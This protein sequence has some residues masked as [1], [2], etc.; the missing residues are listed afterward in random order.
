M[1]SGRFLILILTSVSFGFV[2]SFNSSKVQCIV[3]HLSDKNVSIPAAILQTSRDE[4]C[5]EIVK[6]LSESFRLD[7]ESQLHADDKKT[8]IVNLLLEHRISDIFLKG[9]VYFTMNLTQVINF[10][11]E[12]S[13]TTTDVLHA[14]RVI[15]SAHERYG[16]MFDE[17]LASHRDRDNVQQIVDDSSQ[18]CIKKY[19]FDRNIINPAEFDVDVT[20]I[21]ATECE[22][23]V[24]ALD[25]SSSNGLDVAEG[26]LFYGLP[27]VDVQK[28]T[29]QKFIADRV[30]LKLTSFEV[31]MSF[32]LSEHQQTK[33]RSDYV[34]WMT[35]N[36]RFLLGCLKELL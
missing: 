22:E 2:E 36:V 29:N 26:S 8:C 21:N 18:L 16:K 9:F 10:E 30:L 5:F 34:E 23:I 6:S 24:K 35:A 17:S 15:C 3:E 27:S 7:I 14:A 33:L 20:S 31:T 4:D 1:E 28:C 19:Y 11:T 32:N 13:E 25:E 12:A